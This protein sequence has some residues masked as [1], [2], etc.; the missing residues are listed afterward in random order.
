MR[1]V[2]KGSLWNMAERS[3]TSR[4]RRLPLSPTM[5]SPATA[6]SWVGQR[7]REWRVSGPLTDDCL[8]VT[9]ELV[10]NAVLHGRE[11]IAISASLT[12]VEG[13]GTVPAQDLLIEVSDASPDLA[14]TP[15]TGSRDPFA[16]GGRGLDLVAASADTWYVARHHDDGKSVVAVW[17]DALTR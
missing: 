10:T 11:P 17:H 6:R 2:E 13:D 3:G 9:S 15:R 12:P 8:L 14:R 5:T 1:P 4:S 16:Q 7:L